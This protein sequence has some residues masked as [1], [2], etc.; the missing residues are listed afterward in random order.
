ML[1]SGVADNPPGPPRRWWGFPLL[2]AMRA[3]YLG[4]VARL[5]REHGD[6]TFMHVGGERVYDVFSPE[7][8]RTV[9]VDHAEHL[10]RWERATEVFAQV[11]GQSVLVTEG[12]TWQRQR[13]MLMPAFTPRRVAGYAA[14]MVD[15]ARLALDTAVPSD[16]Y[17][18]GRP[19]PCV[20]FAR[21]ER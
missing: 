7:L 15:A 8:V 19:G 3:D 12:S 1:H 14:L 20:P 5:Q 16:R 10:V 18:A 13:R 2:R 9:L 4:F 11:F 17:G 21:A 6:I